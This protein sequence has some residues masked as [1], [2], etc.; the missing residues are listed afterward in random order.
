MI[1]NFNEFLNESLEYK[2]KPKI[3]SST[4]Y[5]LPNKDELIDINKYNLSSTEILKGFIYTIVGRG[6][7]S[8]QNKENIIKSIKMLCDMYPHN[9]EYKKALVDAQNIKS[10][11][12]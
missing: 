6:I 3:F 9:E 5:R 11:W 10:K 1:I 12:L 7:M 4:Y 8:K 2:Q